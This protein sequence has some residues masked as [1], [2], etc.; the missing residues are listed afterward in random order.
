MAAFCTGSVFAHIVSLARAIFRYRTMKGVLPRR[1]GKGMPRFGR[2]TV[3]GWAPTRGSGIAVAVEHAERLDVMAQ[4]R[5]PAAPEL[6]APIDAPMD[7]KWQ[8]C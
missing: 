4:Y 2:G 8:F 7:V 3:T 1:A 5:V 6:P